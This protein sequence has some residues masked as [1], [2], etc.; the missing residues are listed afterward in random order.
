MLTLYFDGK[1][2]YVILGF[3]PRLRTLAWESSLG[4]KVAPSAS[5]RRD[6]L[7]YY[8]CL[9]VYNAEDPSWGEI[10]TSRLGAPGLQTRS[11]IENM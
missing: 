3:V 8:Y 10:F 9:E 7:R 6:T 11:I 4:Y 1:G 5:L 2:A